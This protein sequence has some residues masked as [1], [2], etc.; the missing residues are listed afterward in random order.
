M[1]RYTLPI[2]NAQGQELAKYWKTYFNSLK[3]RDQS[4]GYSQKDYLYSFVTG[5]NYRLIKQAKKAN[6]SLSG[7][8]AQALDAVNQYQLKD[9]M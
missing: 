1:R 5:D 6:Q 4:L 7:N 8:L 9:F 2:Y 3:G